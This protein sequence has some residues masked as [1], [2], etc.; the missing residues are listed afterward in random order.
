MIIEDAE[1]IREELQNFFK[2]LWLLRLK[3]QRTF[4]IL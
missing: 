3:H 4:Q 1:V 2:P